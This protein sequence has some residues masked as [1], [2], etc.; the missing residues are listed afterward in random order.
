MC[1]RFV[2]LSFH[3]SVRPLCLNSI[4][5]TSL[6]QKGRAPDGRNLSAT[7]EL[8]SWNQ[9]GAFRPITTASCSLVLSAAFIL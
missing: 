6:S 9:R 5:R 3:L 2:R 4:T 8:L 7:A 1:S